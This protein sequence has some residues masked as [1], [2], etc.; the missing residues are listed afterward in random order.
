[1]EGWNNEELEVLLAVLD[2]IGKVEYE[3]RNCVRGAFTNAKTHRELAAC[4][5]QHA[6]ALK[7]CAEAIRNY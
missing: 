3:I 7:E 6:E 2:Q 4:L 1:M 5:E